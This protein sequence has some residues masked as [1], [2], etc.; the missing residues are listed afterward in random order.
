MEITFKPYRI[1]IV[2][3][4]LSPLIDLLGVLH[5]YFNDPNTFINTVVLVVDRGGIKWYNDITSFK[6]KPLAYLLLKLQTEG[7]TKSRP[8]T[9]ITSTELQTNF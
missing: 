6:I 7:S 8:S 2:F 3:N 4:S 9:H 5:F 1:G